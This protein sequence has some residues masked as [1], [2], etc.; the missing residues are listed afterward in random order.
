[1]VDGVLKGLGE[2]LATFRYSLADSVL[3]IAAIC[4]L[5]PRYGMPGFLAVMWASNVTSALLNILRIEKV[6]GIP[7][8]WFGWFFQPALLFAASAFYLTGAY[9]ELD[10]RYTSS[11]A[12]WM[13]PELRLLDTIFGAACIPIALTV[14]HIDLYAETLPV[15]A[16]LD[17]REGLLPGMDRGWRYNKQFLS[18]AF[19][20]FMLL[21]VRTFRTKTLTRGQTLRFLLFP[22]T[23]LEKFTRWWLYVVPFSLVA[24]PLI[25]W[26]ADLTRIL[27]CRAVFPGTNLASPLYRDPDFL[28]DPHTQLFFQTLFTLTLLGQAVL[29]LTSTLKAK[30]LR[31]LGKFCILML[32]VIL[33]YSISNLMRA[34]PSAMD[35]AIIRLSGWHFS[36]LVLTALCWYVAYRRLVRT[37]LTHSTPSQSSRA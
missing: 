3:R 35:V 37:D 19:F 36:L 4:L 11:Y 1:M 17:Q 28:T 20:A 34:Y 10:G 9:F 16:V 31:V 15:K 21:S 6:S 2:Q 5:L 26:A 7:T 33:V 18:V 24:F 12:Y 13:L 29:A 8:R 22:T 30:P 14:I 23:M 32:P 25:Y 27:I